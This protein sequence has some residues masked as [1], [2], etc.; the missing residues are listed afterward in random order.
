MTTGLFNYIAALLS[1]IRCDFSYIEPMVKD[2][3]VIQKV[4]KG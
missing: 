4:K 2:I 3:E 1:N